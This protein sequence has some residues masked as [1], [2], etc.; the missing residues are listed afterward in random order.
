MRGIYRKFP[1]VF[2]IRRES[3]ELSSRKLKIN[4]YKILCKEKG[5]GEDNDI[6]ITKSQNRKNEKYL[7]ENFLAKDF[8]E[9][10]QESR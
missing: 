8:C 6:N 10:S 7:I 2:N 4:W 5:K 3:T 1:L 9:K